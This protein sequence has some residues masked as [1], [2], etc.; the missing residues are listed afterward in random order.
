M[1]HFTKH[2]TTLLLVFFSHI[3]FGQNTSIKI[4]DKRTSDAVSFANIELLNL[5]KTLHKGLTSD[6]NGVAKFNIDKK[7][8]YIVS[9]IG[10]ADKKGEISPGENINIELNVDTEILDAVVVTGQYEAKR[11]D[12]SIYKIDVVTSIQ[13]EERG[14]SNL[15]DAL[16]NES[17]IRIK[18]DP[19]TGTSIEMNGMGG[20]NVK[21]LIDGVPIVGRV[22]GNVDLSQINMDNVDH[23]EIV[24]GPMSVVY[25]TSALAGVIN[26]ITKQNTRNSNNLKANTYLD[27]K[28][29]YNVGVSGSI[30]RG[31]N[32][33]S[34]NSQ[35]NMFQGYDLSPE[36]RPMNFNPELVYNADLEYAYRN[37]DFMIKL[38]TSYM[39]N[40]VLNHGN[41]DTLTNGIVNDYQ[42][43]TTRSSNSITINDRLS[44]K[45]SYNIIGAYT[46]YGRTTNHYQK[47]LRDTISE[48]LDIL[49]QR[50][51]S[52]DFTKFDNI[53]TR[54]NFTYIPSSKLSFQFGWDVNFDSGEGV[55]IK[56][57]KQ[58]MTDYAAFLSAQWKPI[59]KFSI[60]PGFRVIYNTNYS[61]PV[62]PS[63]NFQYEII[64]N[65]SL[66]ASYAKGFRA[67]SLKEQYLYLVGS[68]HNIQGNPDLHAESTNS[69]NA[70]L[71]YKFKDE[72]MLFKI[73]PS[74]FYNHGRDKIF[75][76]I[77]EEETNTATYDNLGETINYGYSINASFL[78]FGGLTTG[79]GFTRI[80]EAFAYEEG[81]DF[82]PFVYY[83]NYTL[84]AKYNFRKLRLVL[85]ANYKLYGETP[86]LRE[87]PDDT[88]NFYYVYTK[89]Y[90]DLE[91]TISKMFWRNRMSVVIGGKNLF[92]NYNT[93]TTGYK[94]ETYTERYSTINYGRTFFV[95]MNIKLS[96]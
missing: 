12:K 88:D 55:K 16:S 52:D 21:Y 74:T 31:K 7:V 56:D 90:S 85:M 63:I 6:A 45:L 34:L 13:L 67:P 62:V 51:V 77:I 82:S 35:R 65:L 54:G 94:G 5:D 91:F 19:S 80:G 28:N 72:N 61:A 50:K 26:I 27:N 17:N 4:T 53:M 81:A 8:K 73:E 1:K 92:D 66:R 75:I 37:K 10:Y 57:E 58:T 39:N 25:G 32:T 93:T 44:E 43:L 22:M 3:A 68:S 71:L 69:Y 40:E 23:I 59:E 36:T 9:F 86:S 49:E 38:K 14:V 78:H 95:R 33:F 46:Y 64:D 83:N 11:A 87:D 18:V 96:N 15:A 41:P 2:I 29:N 30:I 47:N 60:Q 42:Y 48:G 20:E 84:N 24:Q 70:S 76:R 79:I 89:P